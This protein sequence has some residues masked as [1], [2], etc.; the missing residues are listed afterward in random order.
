MKIKNDK[1]KDKPSNY[2]IIIDGIC[3][4]SNY[5]IYKDQK[6]GFVRYQA[7][8]F[9]GTFIVSHNKYQEGHFLCNSDQSWISKNI[10]ID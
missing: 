4:V 6:K 7:D 9:Q 5:D 10:L 3:S 2:L 8:Y 1:I